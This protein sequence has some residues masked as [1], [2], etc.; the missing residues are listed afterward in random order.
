M[1][2][3]RLLFVKPRR[4][5]CKAYVSSSQSLSLY[6]HVRALMNNSFFIFFALAYR[7]LT[8]ALIIGDPRY[9]TFK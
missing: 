4:A 1:R 7:Y 3:R 2:L 5:V 9:H 8:N 6:E